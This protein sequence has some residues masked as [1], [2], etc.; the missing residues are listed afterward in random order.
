MF[1][2]ILKFSIYWI[3]FLFFWQF[4]F[5]LFLNIEINWGIFVAMSIGGVIGKW[6]K[7]NIKN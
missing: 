2:D 3:L 4:T 5:S 6:F 1:K 7:I